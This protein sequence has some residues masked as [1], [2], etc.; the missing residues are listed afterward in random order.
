MVSF[1]LSIVDNF[2]KFLDKFHR[3]ERSLFVGALHPCCGSLRQSFIL[4]FLTPDRL[5]TYL[6]HTALRLRA[7]T[8][9]GIGIGLADSLFELFVR[10]FHHAIR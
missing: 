4:F 6:L 10:V 5:R 7:A 9:P 1:R 8:L 3:L 2:S